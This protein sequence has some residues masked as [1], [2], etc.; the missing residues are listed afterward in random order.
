MQ[1]NRASIREQVR[2]LV[3]HRI[4]EGSL[5]PGQRIVEGN[6]T[7]ELNVSNIPV[8]EAIREL[9]AMGVLQSAPHKGAWVREIS[10][11]ETID[12]LHIKAALEPKAL[13]QAGDRL[14]TKIPGLKQ[15]TKEIVKAARKKDYV[16]F[17]KHNQ[18]FH[19]AIVE[20]SGN[21]LLIKIWD[22]LAFEIRSTFILDFIA[23]QSP[24]DIA[25]EHDRITAAI[26]ANQLEEAASLLAQHAN[27]LID[28]LSQAANQTRHSP[29][30][31]FKIAE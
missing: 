16:A 13:L 24:V 10:L 3:L 31:I 29:Y 30:Q 23:D 1:L 26:E 11:G 12:A 27:R 6:L 4:S 20:A 22:S 7:Q 8:R 18:I 25:Q 2:E 28:Y 5:K 17:G 14:Q 15:A 21:R 19:R 9:V